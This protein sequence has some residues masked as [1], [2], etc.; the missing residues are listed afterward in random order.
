MTKTNKELLQVGDIIEI[1][2]GMSISADIPN[3]FVASN[4]RMSSELTR[5]D[6]RIGE[7][8]KNPMDIEKTRTD[9]EKSLTN[10]FVVTCGASVDP[11]VLHELI[12]LTLNNYQE[13]ELDTSIFA[14]EYLVVDAKKEGGNYNGYEFFD[15]DYSVQCQKLK[16]GQFD[17]NG[18]KIYFYQLGNYAPTLSPNQVQPVRKLTPTF[19]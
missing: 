5:T 15:G 2:E 10:C 9:L 14:G 18:T 7:V 11:V 6:V 4:R 3:K 1:K 19:I 16:D 8:L 17:P 12:E 13:E